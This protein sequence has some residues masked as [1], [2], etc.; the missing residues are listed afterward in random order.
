MAITF[1]HMGNCGLPYYFW[2]V[3]TNVQTLVVSWCS[4]YSSRMV[5]RCLDTTMLS[6][7]LFVVSKFSLKSVHSSV[8]SVFNRLCWLEQLV[9]YRYS[10]Y[11]TTYCALL[12]CLY[13]D[14][15]SATFV[16]INITEFHSKIILS[17]TLHHTE[18]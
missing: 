18:L 10:I 9:V 16:H 4:K 1:R 17:F 2:E 8:S 14:F 11:M 7:I 13:F 12:L 5:H 6:I 3:C 15:L